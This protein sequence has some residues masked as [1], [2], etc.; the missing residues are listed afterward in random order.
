MT[1]ALLHVDSLAG[2]GFSETSFQLAP[3]QWL[4]L[5]NGPRQANTALVDAIF[6]IGPTHGGEVFW[7]GVDVST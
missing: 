7:N 1:P 3:G 6:G 2:P 5:A 4:R